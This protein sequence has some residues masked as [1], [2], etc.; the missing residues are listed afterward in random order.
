MLVVEKDIDEGKEGI[1]P[2]FGNRDTLHHPTELV[3]DIADQVMGHGAW[4]SDLLD[5][6]CN[7]IGFEWTDPNGKHGLTIDV[8]EQDDRSVGGRIDQQ[9]A[10]LDFSLHDILHI[11]QAFTSGIAIY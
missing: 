8:L 10:N 6:R 4:W 3:D 2:H 9:T 11:L 7:R 5:L 1:L